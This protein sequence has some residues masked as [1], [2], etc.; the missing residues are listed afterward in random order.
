MSINNFHI[1]KLLGENFIKYSDSTSFYIQ[2]VSFT[3]N[4][5]K[6]RIAAIQNFLLSEMSNDE[7]YIG[8]LSHDDLDTY[9]SIFALWCSGKAF[10]PLN[11]LNPPERNHEII[12]QMGLKYILNAGNPIGLKDESLK[13]VCQRSADKPPQY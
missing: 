5:F 8:I 4:Q 3:Y 7:K 10:V 12:S 13:F 2:G 6:K 1:L 11:P 9:A